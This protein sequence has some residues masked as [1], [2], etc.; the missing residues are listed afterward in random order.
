MDEILRK[1]LI[2]V[3]KR[4]SPNFIKLNLGIYLISAITG[5]AIDYFLPFSG[6]FMFTRSLVLIPLSVSLFILFY[7]PVLWVSSNKA[8]R[9]WI[10]I[11]RRL[12][13]K[14]RRSLSI[15]AVALISA[16]AYSRD[17]GLSYTLLSGVI[18]TTFLALLVF[19]RPTK[20]EI[21]M[22]KLGIEDYRDKLLSAKIKEKT[23]RKKKK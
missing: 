20:E 22:E 5:I 15:V 10:P 23:A 6:V 14:T 7:I 4:S 12:S 13:L 21:S 8:S 3:R 19:I 11:R 2:E 9:G 1:F 16:L 18:L 17:F